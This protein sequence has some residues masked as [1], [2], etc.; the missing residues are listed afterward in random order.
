MSIAAAHAH[1]FIAEVIAVGEVWAIRDEGG[2][3]TSTNASGEIVM[4]FWSMESRA[5]SIID[6]VPAY[7][8]F[9]PHR[10]SLVDF[11][12]RWLSGLDRDGLMVGLNWSGN[13]ATGFD[14]S[15]SAVRKRIE[16]ARN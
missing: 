1:T 11:V 2:F 4:P 3:P 14:I 7:Q 15:P 9:K 12:E 16:A 10:L 13:H 8:D 5:Q 6:K